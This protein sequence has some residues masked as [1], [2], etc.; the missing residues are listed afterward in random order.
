MSKLGEGG[1][2]V[3]YLAKHVTLGK[4]AAIKVLRPALSSNQDVVSRFFNEARAVTAVRN[5]GIVDVYDFGFL[6]DRTAYIIMEYLEGES[7]AARLRRS[8]PAIPWTLTVVRAI[9]RALQAAHEHGIVHRDLKPDNVFLVPDADLPGGERVKLLDFGIAKLAHGVGDVSHTT[10]G[11][12]MG[13][14]TYM[15]PEQCR[16]AG[17]VDHR[18]DLYSLGCVAY[19]MLCGQPPFVADGPGDV[20]ARHLYFEP[21]PPR[22]RRAEIPPE[23]EE[24]VV[25]LLKKE[26]RARY[27]TAAE[28]VRAIDDL[29]GA[30]SSGVAPSKPLATELVATLPVVRDTTLNGAASSS[31]SLGKD[32]RSRRLGIV[33]AALT[34]AVAAF[35]LVWFLAHGRRGDGSGAGAGVALAEPKGSPDSS[36]ASPPV[37]APAAPR[38][39]TA[40]EGA[41]PPPA[42]AAIERAQGSAAGSSGPVGGGT[43]TPQDPGPKSPVAPVDQHEPESAMAPETSP[44]PVP[45]EPPP[46]PSAASAK[47]PSDAGGQSGGGRHDARRSETAKPSSGRPSAPRSS[48]EGPRHAPARPLESPGEPTTPDRGTDPSSGNGPTPVAPVAPGPGAPPD[49]ECSRAAFAGAL[50]ARAPSKKAVNDARSRLARCKP[51]MDPDLYADIYHRLIE[52]Y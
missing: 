33:T 38:P 51:S 4:K 16:G 41:S 25:R 21:Q 27:A 26:P 32:E 17:A 52:R 29:S 50:D 15:A 48:V 12:V 1:M 40:A 19:E 34:M 28:L 46:G 6:E 43:V 44:D 24:I 42:P 9:A 22:S 31:L 8:R 14:P 2:G 5:P 35:A 11:T 13:T 3:V 23:L 47:P 37:P 39:A 10:T 7:L 30:S 45:A 18:A 20:I 36:A 49:A